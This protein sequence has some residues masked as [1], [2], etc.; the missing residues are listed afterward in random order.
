M[1]YVSLGLILLHI[2]CFY[3]CS[4]HPILER[5]RHLFIEGFLAILLVSLI[6]GLLSDNQGLRFVVSC[7]VAG[8]STGRC[9]WRIKPYSLCTREVCALH[10][11]MLQTAVHVEEV[12]THPNTGL[13]CHTGLFILIMLCSFISAS[14]QFMERDLKALTPGSMPRWL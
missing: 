6:T 9:L 3:W 2:G 5:S 8:C 11:I 10:N 1:W 7:V 13:E 4:A 14:R 12:F